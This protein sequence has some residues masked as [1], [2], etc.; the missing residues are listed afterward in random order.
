MQT[1][2]T[3]YIILLFIIFFAIYFVYINICI[4]INSKEK[5]L[6][7]IC[8]IDERVSTLDNCLKHVVRSIDKK[9]HINIFGIIRKYVKKYF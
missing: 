6:I 4:K 1:Y 7:S 8:C 5:I 9:S 3:N 2:I